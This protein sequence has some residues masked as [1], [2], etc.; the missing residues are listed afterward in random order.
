MRFFYIHCVGYYPTCNFLHVHFDY[1]DHL[2]KMV[3]LVMSFF[4][5]FLVTF[6][7]IRFLRESII[8]G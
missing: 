2:V 4:H 1:F 5:Y 6:R 7:L 8:V 3:N